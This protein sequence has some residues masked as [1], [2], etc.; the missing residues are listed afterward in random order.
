M[1][2]APAGPNVTTVAGQA[3]GWGYPDPSGVC[4]CPPGI[5]G[6]MCDRIYLPSCRMSVASAVMP[7][8][9]FNGPMS[10]R[11]AE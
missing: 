6:V 7:C 11:C 2:V 4:V 1:A 3:C 5:D 10:C 8:E 9:G